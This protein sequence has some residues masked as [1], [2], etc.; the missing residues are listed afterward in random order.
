MRHLFLNGPVQNGT[1]IFGTRPGKA[2]GIRLAAALNAILGSPPAPHLWN[3]ATLAGDLRHREAE[4]PKIPVS[5]LRPT[6]SRASTRR[7]SL[8][9]AAS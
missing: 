7:G 1:F 4:G 5:A 3:T 2:V 9:Q 6:S 8:R